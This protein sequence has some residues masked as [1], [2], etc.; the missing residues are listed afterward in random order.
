MKEV[1]E[2]KTKFYLFT[3][4]LFIFTAVLVNIFESLSPFF[5]YIVFPIEFFLLSF[6]W[7]HKNELSYKKP[8]AIMTI[9][10]LVGCIFM[11]EYMSGLSIVESLTLGLIAILAIKITRKARKIELNKEDK[12]IIKDEKLK[13]VVNFSMPLICIVILEIYYKI[14]T[15]GTPKL[16]LTFCSL[17]LTLIIAY[18][19]YLLVL[20]VIRN[21]FVTTLTFFLVFLFLFVANQMRIFYT[22]DTLLLTDVSFLE[23]TGELTNFVD[24]TLINAINY[25]IFPTI[26]VGAIFIYLL[27]ICYNL[28]LKQRKKIFAYL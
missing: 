27:H 23:T 21:T 16:T 24:V 13:K 20:S 19:I 14:C 9:Y 5:M 8:I 25:V 10:M 4:L 18:T 7:Y 11:Y 17:V 3:T 26:I 12:T 2:N 15:F 22:S 28:Y 1:F 6:M